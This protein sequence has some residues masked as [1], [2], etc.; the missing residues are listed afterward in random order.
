MARHKFE[1]RYS[2]DIVRSAVRRYY[3]DLMRRELTWRFRFAVALVA[4]A[5]GYGLFHHQPRW[6]EGLTGAILVL[7]PTLL[8]AGYIAHLRQGIAKLHAMPLPMATF[9]VTDDTLEVSSGGARRT[10]PWSHFAAVLESPNCLVLRLKR[11]S[12]LTVPTD[13]VDGAITNFI[14]GSVGTTRGVD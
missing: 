5:F 6:L 12:S 11:G 13:G 2:E 7:V 10:I 14:R 4:G 9:V 8:F 1:V 3:G